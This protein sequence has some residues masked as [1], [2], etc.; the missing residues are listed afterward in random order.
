MYPSEE[1]HSYPHHYKA[2]AAAANISVLPT[3]S[4]TSLLTKTHRFR[5]PQPWLRF[6]PYLIPASVNLKQSMRP[7]RFRGSS[8]SL[9]KS[10]T[11]ESSPVSDN[12]THTPKT[13]WRTDCP[14]N[15]NGSV[16]ELQ[17]MHH[18]MRGTDKPFPPQ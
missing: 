12:Q 6:S 3:C 8:N 10:G 18:L 11:K 7:V 13:K 14:Q 2:A 5:S 15:M 4:S 1:L 9:P 17:T 16:N